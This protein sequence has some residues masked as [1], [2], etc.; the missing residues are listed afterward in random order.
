MP[1]YTVHLREDALTG[2]EPQLITALTDAVGSVFGPDFGKLVGVDLIGLPP[3]RRA[4]GGLPQTGPAPQVTL[5]MREA[6]YTHPAVPEAPQRLI[7]AIT[8]AVAGVLGEE[9]R[10]ETLVTLVGVPEG[11]TGVGGRLV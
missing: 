2:R 8:D 9:T 3:H 11:R 7:G 5:S 1:H 4:T 6:A 10:Q